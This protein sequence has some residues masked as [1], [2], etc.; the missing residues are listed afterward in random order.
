M[1]ARQIS[2]AEGGVSAAT[3]AIPFIEE[4]LRWLPHGTDRNAGLPE[5]ELDV[6][7]ADRHK[8]GRALVMVVDDN[9]DMRDYLRRLLSPYY[10]LEVVGDGGAALAAMARRKPDLVLTDIMIPGLDGLEL[11]K[12]LRA[13][14]AT[15]TIPIILLSARAGEENR[16]D[17]MRAG[18]DDYLIKPFSAR[19]LLARVEA[20]LKMSRYR[21][22]A[23]ETLRA[24]EERF[25]AFVTASSDV[26]Y[27]V[28]PDWSKMRYLQGQDF[29]ADADDPSESWLAK[30]IHPEDR[31][32]I[33]AAIQ[34]AIRNEGSFELEHR[35]IRPDGGLGWTLSRAIPILGAE[36]EIIE[37][38]GAARDITDRK[39]AEET[40]QLLLNELN[41]RVKNMLASV[42]AISRQTLRT[43]R[44]P[45][46]FADSF[47]GRLQSMS[48]MHSLLTDSGWEGADLREIIHDQLLPGAVDDRRVVASGPPVRLAPQTALHTAMM[49]HEL[50]TNSVKYGALSRPE[51]KIAIHWSVSG[52]SLR[53]GWKETGGPPIKTPLGRGFGT[54]LIEQTVKGEGG[55]AHRTIE[56]DGMRWE[57]TLP[58]A[59]IDDA[60]P[61]GPSDLR[62]LTPQDA[63]TSTASAFANIKGKKFA[64]I[65][66][67]PLIA[68]NITSV[69]Q[70]GGA[71]VSGPAATV[72]DALRI[73]E[74]SDLDGALVDANLRGRPAGDIA[75]ALTRKMIPFVFVTGYGREALPAGFARTIILKKPFTEEQLLETL[76]L[77]VEQPRGILRLR[78]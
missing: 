3:G 9:A 37:W 63:Q 17:G 25:R 18:A 43:A 60:T 28:S 45:T 71:E 27:R 55:S 66:D 53:L 69:L 52:R 33:M 13:D 46:D 75:A 14:P 39:R 12:R 30:Y 78:D 62:K 22:H 40:Q 7:A 36:G 67:E 65:E 51:G 21:T 72:S 19:E 74:E 35:I 58:L 1:P 44:D 57:I 34:D 11:L 41:H 73:I 47:S 54:K 5:V 70:Q 26:V 59:G 49:L 2:H 64:V 38:F 15:N 23:T 4:A 24:S 48:R 77:L 8:D 31:A 56:A 16:V 50:C 10:E 20:H 68:V 32:R 42:Q 76:A 29:V 6:P 61:D